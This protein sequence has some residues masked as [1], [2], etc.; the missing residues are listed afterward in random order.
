MVHGLSRTPMAPALLCRCAVQ[1]SSGQ[2]FF[3]KGI[4]TECLARLP[5]NPDSKG[6]LWRFAQDPS[7]FSIKL[8]LNIYFECF[9]CRLLRFS[10]M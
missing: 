2:K 8:F 7:N 6:V 4:L 3:T 10:G 1:I 9:D 5:P